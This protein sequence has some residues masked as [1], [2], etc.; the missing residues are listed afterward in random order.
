VRRVDI[1]VEKTLDGANSK[2]D[3]IM[4]T[5]ENYN[6]PEKEVGLDALVFTMFTISF[7]CGVC[8]A[9]NCAI[10]IKRRRQQLA[11]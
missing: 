9:I 5:N 2:G 8:F 11:F 6:R 4:V 1:Y 7:V 10:F 3:Y